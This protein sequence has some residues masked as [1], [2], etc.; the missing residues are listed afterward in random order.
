MNFFTKDERNT[1]LFLV[2]A[3]M[4][5]FS[6]LYFR[7]NNRNLELTLIESNQE[8]SDV[9]KSEQFISGKIN[10]NMAS[11]AELISLPGI[12]PVTAEKIVAKRLK[13]GSFS[14]IEDLLLVPGIGAKTL[15]KIIDFIEI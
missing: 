5:G 10:L 11:V 1:V 7:D 15:E 14:T 13:M 3:F 12:G 4:I 8:I 2:I 6:I 9:V